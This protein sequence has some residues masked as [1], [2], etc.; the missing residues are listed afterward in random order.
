MPADTRRADPT[1]AHD[2]KTLPD[3]IN[4]F[5]ANR[6]EGV[7]CLKDIPDEYLLRAVMTALYISTTLPIAA[8]EIKEPGAARDIAHAISRH[9]DKNESDLTVAIADILSKRILFDE[10]ICE[11]DEP[12]VWAQAEIVHILMTL[13]NHALFEPGIS[14]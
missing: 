12:N 5:H 6:P 7:K 13:L 4:W 3:Q 8:R 9:L 14:S 1:E 2:A 11:Y 10:S